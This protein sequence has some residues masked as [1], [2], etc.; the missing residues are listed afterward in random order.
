MRVE[1]G[2]LLAATSLLNHPLCLHPLLAFLNLP[3]SIVQKDPTHVAQVLKWGQ[4]LN[5]KFQPGRSWV[6][7]LLE[8]E[9]NLGAARRAS[10]VRITYGWGY[11]YQDL[12]RTEPRARKERE[13]GTVHMY[14]CVRQS[15]RMGCN[16]WNI[17]DTCVVI[18]LTQCAEISLHNW[19]ELAAR[20]G[21]AVYDRLWA[22]S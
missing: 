20:V 8:R 13:R 22:R 7:P 15:E 4:L 14:M 11:H 12:W 3:G 17:C 18:T 10:F 5:Y 6:R 16:L 2:E 9:S 1:E 19:S 21:A